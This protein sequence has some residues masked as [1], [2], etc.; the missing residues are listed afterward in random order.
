MVTDRQVRRLMS[1]LQAEQSLLVSADKVGMDRETARKY[2][3]A[4]KLPSELRKEHD[5][6]RA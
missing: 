2:R 6:R 1:L 3:S 4:G 5:C